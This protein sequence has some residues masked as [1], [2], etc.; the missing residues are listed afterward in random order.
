MN[1]SLRFIAFISVLLI[2]FG[3]IFDIGQIRYIKTNIK[4]SLD[5]STKAAALQWDR[6]ETKIGQ[7]IFD[8]DE[9]KAVETNEEYFADNMNIGVYGYDIETTVI[10]AHSQYIYTAPDGKKYTIDN[11]TIFSTVTYDYDGYFI[12]TKIVV[13]L[14]SGSVLRNKNDLIRTVP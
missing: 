7:G 3:L 10:N 14:T 5:L 8:I 4:D 2:I 6:D 12:N 11:P 1:G 13:P 9:I